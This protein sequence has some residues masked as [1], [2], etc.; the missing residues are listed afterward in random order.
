MSYQ[1]DFKLD[2][3][4]IESNLSVLNNA[5]T[6]LNN[7]KDGENICKDTKAQHAFTFIHTLTR[8]VSY[9]QAPNSIDIFI[10][11]NF[12]LILTNVLQHLAQ[13]CE[14]LK[15]GNNKSTEMLNKVSKTDKALFLSTQDILNLLVST[16]IKFRIDFFQCGGARAMFRLLS[17]QEFVQ[18]FHQESFF[19]T[20]IMNVNWLSK[21]ADQFKNEWL[22]MDAVNILLQTTNYP[23]CKL[24]GYMAFA[25]IA[26]D[27]QIESLDD[28]H[29]VISELIKYT[30]QA[31]E[32]IEIDGSSLER[33]SQQFL[34]D[35]TTPTEYSVLYI[36][37]DG[38]DVQYSITGILLG[39]YKLSVNNR[40]KYDLFVKYNLKEYLKKI[41][42]KGVEIEKKYSLQ[43][44]AQLCFDDQV[45]DIVTKDV[46]LRKYIEDLTKPENCPMK[47]MRKL[48]EQIKWAIYM[49]NK[50][51]DEETTQ[52]LNEPHQQKQLMISY[53]S[54]SRDLCMKVKEELEKNGFRIWIDVNEIH[55]SSLESMA[56]AVESSDFVLMCV[57]EKYRQS[58][59]CQ[60]EAQYAFKLKKKIVPLI[61]QKGYENVDGWLGIIMGDKIF[62]NFNKH[63]FEKC[64]ALILH[65][66]NLATNLDA[67]NAQV[68]PSL[69][70]IAE[71]T[72]VS[73]VPPQ[74][75][76]S[77]G[78]QP[79]SNVLNWSEKQVQNWF[80]EKKVDTAIWAIIKPCNGELLHQL[81]TLQIGCPEF[82]FQSITK[83]SKV[84]LRKALV[85]SLNL[86]KLFEQ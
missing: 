14:S 38:Y 17:N 47:T 24:P 29:V 75:I 9:R 1:N 68:A 70:S 57:T 27:K 32:S 2:N 16:N 55:G 6:Y 51:Q 23:I 8:F 10:E 54:A 53:N 43:L 62:V 36:L 64:L 42:M 79:K 37:A 26:N 61:M 20:L 12:C 22:E 4:N 41:I 83:N 69:F 78:A 30:R 66:M 73:L 7:I 35:D 82:F 48:C 45:L 46:E 18:S 58:V 31:A 21:D 28:M 19:N 34:E 63:P 50:K 13:K 49:K 40:I 15:T 72:K 5:I 76:P 84:D 71:A 44:L 3:Q 81:F 60:A 52:R 11:K 56:R 65:E 33:G 77:V 80:E 25:N 67:K 59:N 85:F 86:K 74:V 39:L